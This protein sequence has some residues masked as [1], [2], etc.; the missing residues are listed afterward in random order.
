MTYLSSIAILRH[1]GRIAKLIFPQAKASLIM[2]R[3]QSLLE[4]WF[5]F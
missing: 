3:S 5:H 4:S 1:N 2:G